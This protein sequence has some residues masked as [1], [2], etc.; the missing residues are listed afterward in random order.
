[1][2]EYKSHNSPSSDQQIVLV[3]FFL[4]QSPFLL[5]TSTLHAHTMTTYMCGCVKFWKKS[6]WVIFN[7]LFKT[8]LKIFQWLYKIFDN[9]NLISTSYFIIWMYHHSLT[10]LI[11][12][13]FRLLATFCYC[14]HW[15]KLHSYV[16]RV[17]PSLRTS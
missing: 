8:S 15:S 10:S 7:L 17:N 3:Y 5:Y 13:I 6:N 16:K 2:K 12:L 11:L 14:K 1:M 9:L 4:S